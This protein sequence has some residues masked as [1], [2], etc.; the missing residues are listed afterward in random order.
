MGIRTVEALQN[1]GYDKINNADD[2]AQFDK[3]MKWEGLAALCSPPRGRRWST[4]GPT[5]SSSFFTN[6]MYSVGDHTGSSDG[7]HGSNHY[8]PTDP[9]GPAGP[10]QN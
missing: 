7:Q 6:P 1:L 4:S 2:L 5:K 10:L 8:H 9:A 3:D